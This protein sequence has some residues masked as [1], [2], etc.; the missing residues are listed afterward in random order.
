MKPEFEVVND[1]AAGS[2]T[3]E[4]VLRERRVEHV[5]DELEGEG[6]EG[7]GSGREQRR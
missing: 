3:G 1:V 4:E 6:P 2:E 5:E 7:Q